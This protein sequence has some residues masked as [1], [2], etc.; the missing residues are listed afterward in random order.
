MAVFDAPGR[1]DKK[2]DMKI[3]NPIFDEWGV[4]RDAH[5]KL[6]SNDLKVAFLAALEELED[7]E[8]HRTRSFP[9]TR[10][11]KVVGYKEPVYRADVDKISG[12]RIHLQYDGGEIHLKDLIEGPKHD[13]VLEQIKA[14]KE[15]YEKQAE[16]SAKSK[17]RNKAR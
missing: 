17:S 2:A 12:S 7:N 1:P 16:T 15:R 11:H 5:K 10:L 13:D 14:K 4:I 3:K 9:R 8:C 6:P